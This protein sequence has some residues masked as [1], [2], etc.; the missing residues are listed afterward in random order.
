MQ[1]EPVLG[2]G[3][4]TG[5][6][7]ES[8]QPDAAQRGVGQQSDDPQS[9]LSWYRQLIHLR[10]GHTALRTGSTTLIDA[11][12]APL[13]GYVRVSGTETLLVIH[14]FAPSPQP[15]AIRLPSLPAGTYGAV[16]LLV[17][18]NALPCTVDDTGTLRGLDMT[19]AP[20]GTI[21]LDVSRT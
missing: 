4:T 2:G 9:L 15:V 16:D 17:G 6:P 19:I 5:V 11:G 14:S 10:L 1:W 20:C 7:W 13:L 18:G 12:T 8:L 21:I 3:F